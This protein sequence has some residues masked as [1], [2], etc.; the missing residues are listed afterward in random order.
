MKR[1]RWPELSLGW[2]I[3]RNF[4]AVLLLCLPI[5]Y[6]LSCPLPTEELSFRRLERQKLLGRSEI[7]L[8]I[9]TQRS[10]HL[11]VGVGDRHVI[12][13]DVRKDRAAYF[14]YWSLESWEGVKLLSMPGFYDCYCNDSC[15]GVVALEMPEGAQRAE[16]TVETFGTVYRG[17]GECLENGVWLFHMKNG[18]NA[19]YGCPYQLTVYGAGEQVLLKQEGELRHPD[20]G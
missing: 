2:K 18:Q 4:L 5:W 13:A 8:H 19:P 17:D 3:A 7:V 20:Y 6:A 15:R 9:P 14:D 11:F 16:L 1:I 12:A 10:H